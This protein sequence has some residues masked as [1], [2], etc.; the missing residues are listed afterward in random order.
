MRVR[1]SAG[2][3]RGRQSVPEGGISYELGGGGGGGAAPSQAYA[4]SGAAHV[5]MCPAGARLQTSI[6]V[7][8]VLCFTCRH[9]QLQ[10][11]LHF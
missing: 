11:L 4:G 1:D 7:T 5:G 10:L 8:G 2:G 6:T 9:Y 3:G